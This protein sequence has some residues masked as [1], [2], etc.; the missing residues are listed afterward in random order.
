VQK[1]CIAALERH[2]QHF[3]FRKKKIMIK[4]MYCK[5]ITTSRIAKTV[6][7]SH[8]RLSELDLLRI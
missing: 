5:R 4:E 6:V 8:M 3:K 1:E 2:P 7:E